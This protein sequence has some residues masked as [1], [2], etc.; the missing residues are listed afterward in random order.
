MAEVIKGVY[1]WHRPERTDYYRI[2]DSSFEGFERGYPDLFEGRCCS[3]KRSILLGEKI[4][5]IVNPS[6]ISISHS[7][8]LKYCGHISGETGSC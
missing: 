6:L 7:L 1:N 8:F 3:T 2:I 4:R 5:E